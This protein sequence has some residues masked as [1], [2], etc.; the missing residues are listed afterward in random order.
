MK[1]GNRRAY[2]RGNV[3]EDLLECAARMLRTESL[4]QIT[5]RRLAGAI[6]ITPGN[7]YNHFENLNELLAQWGQ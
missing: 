4:D 2:H 5:V 7:V 6:G 1:Q 3:R